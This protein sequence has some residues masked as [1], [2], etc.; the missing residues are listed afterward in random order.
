[1]RS[2]NFRLLVAATLTL[3]GFLGLTGFALDRAFQRSALTAVQDRLQGQVYTLLSAAKFE[4]SNERMMPSTLPDPRLSTPSSGLYAQLV[5]ED[6]SLLW[7]SLSMLGLSLPVD[8]PA[9]LGAPSFG[10][11]MVSDGTP[12]FMLAFSVAWEGGD[13]DSHVYTVQVAESRQGY[14]QQM[15]SFRRSL[16]GWF[17]AAGVVLLA[18]QALILRWGLRPLRM[19]AEEVKQVE[20]G[21]KDALL[22]GYPTELQRLVTNLNALIRNSTAHL[23]RYRQA[24]GDL[25]HSFKTPLAVMR[26]A[27]ES[28]ARPEDLRE[29]VR[30]QVNRLDHTVAYQLQRAAASGRSALATPIAV[31]PV[32]GKVVQS[33]MKVYADKGLTFDK[34]VGRRLQFYGDEGDLIEILGN[35]ADNACKW[36][37][38]RVRLAA[39]RVDGTQRSRGGI[40]LE[41]DDDGPGIPTAQ[42]DAIF[43]RG[44]RGNTAVEGHGIG[45]AVVKELVEAVYRGNLTVARSDLGGASVRA[46]VMF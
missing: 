23:E 5:G 44:F 28:G 39:R 36:A 20:A 4:A 14:L 35:L 46:R 43:Q 11:A 8:R 27:A 26:S 7:R 18:V 22:G 31:E 2:L 6:G 38:R 10:T 24:L 12:V 40:E 34:S 13:G 3:A 37:S 29:T 41:V 45:L 42:W 21:H 25:A 15:G 16:W 33:L 19:V 17:A 32:V 9:G 1:M 30:E